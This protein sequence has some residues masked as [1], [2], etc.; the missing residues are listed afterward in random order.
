VGLSALSEGPISACSGFGFVSDFALR[1]SAFPTARLPSSLSGSKTN[2]RGCQH[3]NRG[4][5][6]PLASRSD[7]AKVLSFIRLAS[8]RGSEMAVWV[9]FWPSFCLH[10]PRGWPGVQ[11][12]AVTVHVRRSCA[13]ASGV[14]GSPFRDSEEAPAARSAWRKPI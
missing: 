11:S 5:E 6:P 9:D 13:A 8:I 14:E 2:S 4:S 7:L 10:K 1:I 3:L 12:R